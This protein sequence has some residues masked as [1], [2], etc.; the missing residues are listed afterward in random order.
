[1]TRLVP[2]LL[3]FLLPLPLPAQVQVVYEGP[4]MFG[5]LSVRD[6]EG[7]RALVVG[8]SDAEQTA[9]K[10]GDPLTLVHEYNRLLVSAIAARPQAR[11]VLV[12]GL[13]GGALPLFLRARFPQIEVDAV[14]IDPA[15]VV[16]AQEY[17]GVKLDEKLRV[18]VSDARAFLEESK[19]RWDVVILDAYAGDSVPA[20]LAGADFVRLA[21]A[22]L[23][24]G[25]V[26]ASNVWGPPS[27]QY[28]RLLAAHR[29]VFP[30]LL[31]VEGRSELNH[32]LLGFTVG[33]AKCATV[34]ASAMKLDLP[35][36]LHEAMAGQCSRVP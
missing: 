12:I 21:R 25:G 15:V 29:A 31:V 27:P 8:D 9:I 30:E 26:V 6:Y 11:R 22:R 34:I 28:E 18:H 7:I 17:F 35:F 3:L 4:S 23:S 14:E 33:P 32:V 16:V 19:E 20:H 36:P 2:L 5:H 13:G 1:M 10:L 24:K